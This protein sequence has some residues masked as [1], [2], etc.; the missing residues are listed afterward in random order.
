[1]SA[2]L[3]LRLPGLSTIRCPLR[4]NGQSQVPKHGGD[5]FP[6]KPPQHF[7]TACPLPYLPFTFMGEGQDVAAALRFL[8]PL[9]FLKVYTRRACICLT[10]WPG[11]KGRQLRIFKKGR[12][13][14][15]TPRVPWPSLLEFSRM[16]RFGWRRGRQGVAAARRTLDFL[17]SSFKQLARCSLIPGMTCSYP[18]RSTLAAGSHPTAFRR[19]C[20]RP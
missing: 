16:D 8:D 12:Q 20:V 5:I 9:L 19:G 1:M 2:V 17:N 4:E 6:H 18:A 3:L 15:V 7:R 14:V 13:G 11:H 10:S